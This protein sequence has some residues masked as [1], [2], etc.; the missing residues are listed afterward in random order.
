MAVSNY[1]SIQL[2]RETKERLKKRGRMGD[3]YESIL[4]KLMDKEDGKKERA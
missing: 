3:S 4:L 1:T 2:T